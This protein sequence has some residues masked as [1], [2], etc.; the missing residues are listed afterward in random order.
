[1]GSLET[2]YLRLGSNITSHSEICVFGHKV[3]FGH[4]EIDFGV[5]SYVNE[6]EV[7][8]AVQILQDGHGW[9]NPDNCSR[10]AWDES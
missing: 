8:R 4:F 5:R 1:M 2:P 3:A 9:G 7:A 6:P 10:R